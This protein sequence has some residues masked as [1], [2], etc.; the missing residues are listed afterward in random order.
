MT[1]AQRTAGASLLLLPLVV[2]A[3]ATAPAFD[4][5]R[6]VL[7]NFTSEGGMPPVQFDHWRH[8]ALYTCRVCHVDVGFAMAAGETKVSAT[9]NQNG[10]HCGACHNGR[11]TYGGGKLIFAACGSPAEQNEAR[12]HR[13]HTIGDSA[14]RRRDFEAFAAGLPRMGSGGEVDWQA[15]QEH[16]QIKPRDVVE[17]ASISRR[18]IRMDRN[19]TIASQGWMTDVLFSHQKHAVWNGCEVCHPDIYPHTE[20]PVRRTML[21]ITE[22]ESCGACHG[23]VAFSLE[24]CERCHVKPV[25]R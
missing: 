20:A 4:Y 9:T 23:K 16:W 5:G 15:A 11:S 6:I 13:C 10:F 14:Q 12:C 19:V 3:W 22:G 25:Q 21:E 18:S 7:S 1:P 17:G 24:H 8:R 2:S